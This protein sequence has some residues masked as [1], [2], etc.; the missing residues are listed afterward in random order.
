MNLLYEIFE[1]EVVLE[2]N[3]VLQAINKDYDLIDSLVGT[4]K[5]ERYPFNLYYLYPYLFKDDFINVSKDNFNLIAEAGVLY[6]E[7]INFYD[8]YA[9]N[10]SHADF[11]TLIQ[12]SLSCQI[13]IKIL[14]QLFDRDNV[15]WSYLERYNKEY[16][17]AVTLER[18]NHFGVI[19]NFSDEE[20]KIIARGKSAIAKATVAALGC[21]S[22]NYEQIEKLELTQD[23]FAEA[24][25]LL[26]DL[27]DF[28]EDYKLKNYS[29]IL[30]KLL[31]ESKVEREL[32]EKE[33]LQLLVES[34][35]YE[36]ALNKINNLCEQAMMCAGSS[37][38]WIRYI[39]MF[40]RR[41]SRLKEDLCSLRGNTIEKYTYTPFANNNLLSDPHQVISNVFKVLIKEQE[42]GFGELSHWML[43]PHDLDYRGKEECQGGD[44]FQRALILNLL[45]EMKEMGFDIGNNYIKFEA[46]Y[47]FNKM[48]PIY[49]IG[50]SYFPDLPELAP[51]IDTLSEII[52]IYVSYPNDMV[53]KHIADCIDFVLDNNIVPDGSILTWM[54]DPKDQSELIV[55]AWTA[56][57]EKWGVRS[58]PEVTAN[59][60]L[61]L[62]SLDYDTYK[63]VVNHSLPWIFSKQNE[64]GYWL[65]TWYTGNYYGSYICS[66]LFSKLNIRNE[67]TDRLASFLISSQNEDGSWGSNGANPQDTALAI[68]SLIDLSH[69]IENPDLYTVLEKGL[70]YL[71]ST[72]NNEFN[73]WYG[74]NFIK[75]GKERVFSKTKSGN[76]IEFEYKV[77]YKSCTLTTAICTYALYKVKK[78]LDRRM[79]NGNF[80][81]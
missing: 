25:Q 34:D 1:K 55:R 20:F 8:R 22:G 39:K 11:Y 27:K 18:E 37:M 32:S 35:C 80:K 69:S 40:Q 50:W 44:I 64:N 43:F 28:K 45:L 49:D 10:Q 78:F 47:L 4:R 33:L 7:N 71:I 57:R 16:I 72:F 54:L 58:D 6:L 14:S 46:D 29:W 17:N 23:I 59:F 2:G 48:S 24:F 60:L 15:F 26:D 62:S 74:Y 21:L 77:V 3:K 70:N 75:M 81:S 5:V 9:D 12:K 56:A 53:K 36:V 65:S 41:A 31:A 76:A 51:D 79:Y 73:I 66:K 63:N 19:N 30:T 61:A 42:K 68:S 13:S 38:P 52:K 67:Q